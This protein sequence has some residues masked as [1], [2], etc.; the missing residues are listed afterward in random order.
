MA[1][2]AYFKEPHRPNLA[3]EKMANVIVAV[4]IFCSKVLVNQRRVVKRRNILATVPFVLRTKI[5]HNSAD[6]HDLACSDRRVRPAGIFFVLLE[7]VAKHAQR[8]FEGVRANRVNARSYLS[9]LVKI[10]NQFITP[11]QNK[12]GRGAAPLYFVEYRRYSLLHF[13]FWF[14]F[15]FCFWFFFCVGCY[16]S[17]SVDL[18]LLAFTR[19]S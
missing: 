7:V 15:W 6:T 4:A 17:I 13:W 10:K 19:C 1:L 11:L 18:F 8:F 12:G 5:R 3:G 14:F 16:R 9:K 2:I